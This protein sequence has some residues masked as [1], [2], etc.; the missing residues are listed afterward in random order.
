MNRPLPTV[1]PSDDLDDV[2]P[3]TWSPQ[4][5]ALL[6][7]QYLQGMTA[8]ESARDIGGVSRHAV[9]SKRYRMGLFG[10][11]GSDRPRLKAVPE[12]DTGRVRYRRLTPREDWMGVTPLPPM[13]WS[14]PPDARP[15]TLADR[16]PR[17][18]AWPLGPAEAP[19]EATTLF[20]CAPLSD[21]GPYCEAHRQR[22]RQPPASPPST[23]GQ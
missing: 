3:G 1:A 4:R 8:A 21:P 20:C 7:L 15:A 6:H 23:G 18:C 17:S 19:G 11:G 10:R 12:P 5:V 9:I 2:W 22:A 14:P 16:P 13:D